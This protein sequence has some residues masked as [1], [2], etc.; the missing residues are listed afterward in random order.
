MKLTAIAI[1]QMILLS[2]GGA[3]LAGG[4]APPPTPPAAR[5]AKSEASFV[6]SL[7]QD[8][9]V[10]ERVATAACNQATKSA[11]RD[12]GVMLGADY[13]KWAEELSLF[14]AKKSVA[15]PDRLESSHL[16]SLVAISRVSVGD[17]DSAYLF[18][19]IQ[20]QARYMAQIEPVLA[21]TNDLEL[22]AILSKA[23]ACVSEHL[24]QARSV[25]RVYLAAN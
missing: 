3:I 15:L 20:N 2:V 9:V 23:H 5:L 13:R 19:T 16:K 24:A 7:M 8:C 14:A 17:F 11:V 25:Q 4:Q 10:E 6:A 1:L 12:L 18:L 21:N 22:K